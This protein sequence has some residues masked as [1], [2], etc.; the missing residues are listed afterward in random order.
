MKTKIIYSLKLCQ[1]LLEHDCV[2]V[3]VLVEVLPS[4][5][6]IGY[7]AWKFEDSEHLKECIALFM[8]EKEKEEREKDS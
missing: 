5:F 7:K 3:D 2:L 4:P 1:F 6:K 8:K